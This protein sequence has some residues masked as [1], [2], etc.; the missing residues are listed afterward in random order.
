MLHLHGRRLKLKRQTQGEGLLGGRIVDMV[1][2]AH[3]AP[4]LVPKRG[5]QAGQ[6]KED[7]IVLPAP[8]PAVQSQTPIPLDLGL[9]HTLH[10]RKG[11]VAV[12][13]GVAPAPHP[14]P[15][16]GPLPLCPTPLPGE[17]GTRIPPLALAL[18]VAPGRGHDPLRDNHSGVVA[19]HCTDPHVGLPVVPVHSQ[20]WKGGRNGRRKPLRN[21]GLF[22][23]V[24]FGEQ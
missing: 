9:D 23:L 24:E 10:L 8:C 12:S 7:P 2:L 21:A 16:L 11:I 13:L 4:D 6:E 19:E 1:L 22:T 18:G 3:P 17:E 15:P 5:A 20:M 14:V